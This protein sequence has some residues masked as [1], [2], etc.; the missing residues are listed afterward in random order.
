MKKTFCDGC[1]DEIKFDDSGTVKGDARVGLRIRASCQT[2]GDQ[3]L[4]QFAQDNLDLCR[5]C[6]DRMKNAM[7]PRQWPRAPREA[8][9]R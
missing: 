3:E 6:I 4:G 8:P 7:D 9:A 5:R 2:I 1:D